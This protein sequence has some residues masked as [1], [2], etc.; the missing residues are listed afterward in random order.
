MNHSALLKR[1]ALKETKALDSVDK[2]KS[3]KHKLII[4][5]SFESAPVKKHKDLNPARVLSTPSDAKSYDLSE[6]KFLRD[7]AAKSEKQNRDKD[8]E[9][10]ED[11][12]DQDEEEFTNAPQF[13]ANI[14]FEND[15]DLLDPNDSLDRT[16]LKLIS[17]NH[18]SGRE[19]A[20]GADSI[21][22]IEYDYDMALR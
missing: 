22:D 18:R 12:S 6:L 17:N 21:T 16:M 11:G 9:T 19:V 15:L 3:S 14:D 20:T 10:S 1:D 2:T 7:Q 8:A 13:Y 4:D 5:S